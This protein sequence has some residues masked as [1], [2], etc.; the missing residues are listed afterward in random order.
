MPAEAGAVLVAIG[1]ITGTNIGATIGVG[2]GVGKFEAAG[3]VR[4]EN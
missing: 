4:I 2:I 3:N 1:T